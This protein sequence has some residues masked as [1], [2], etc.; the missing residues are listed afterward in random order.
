MDLVLYDAVRM[1]TEYE[2]DQ[3]STE[4][5][6]PLIPMGSGSIHRFHGSYFE[7]IHD[8]LHMPEQPRVVSIRND[9]GAGN[10]ITFLLLDGLGY[11]YVRGKGTILIG[12]LPGAERI[13]L[14]S[15]LS[16]G[17]STDNNNIATGTSTTTKRSAGVIKSEPPPYG[18]AIL[19][20]V[21]DVDRKRS[22]RA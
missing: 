22:A 3:F 5:P 7:D 11:V 15:S 9:G 10:R 6:I 18:F 2:G 12:Q 8:F 16:S 19:L 20:R 1:V 21:Q 14:G 13:P 4:G 17:S